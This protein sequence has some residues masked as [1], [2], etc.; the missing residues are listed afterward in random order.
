MKGNKF[1]KCLM[2]I[3]IGMIFLFL[4]TYLISC[5]TESDVVRPSSE[6][7]N[8]GG[9][10]ASGSWLSSTEP[11][12]EENDTSGYGAQAMKQ[13]SLDSYAYWKSYFENQS[14]KREL[15]YVVNWV[16]SK[17][18]F[19]ALSVSNKGIDIW[20]DNKK[21][22]KRIQ[23]EEEFTKVKEYLLKTEFDIRNNW[24]SKKRIT[25]LKRFDMEEIHGNYC[26]EYVGNKLSEYESS[27]YKKVDEDYYNYTIYYE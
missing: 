11:E 3:K 23:S 6:G 25:F 24:I 19:M 18:Y 15:D 13:A 27:Y 10:V 12:N 1:S 22:K 17:D 26:L 2:V 14:E 4:I 9:Y 5:K 8:T 7:D 16:K 21:T 20:P